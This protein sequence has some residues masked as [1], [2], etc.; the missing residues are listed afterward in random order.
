MDKSGRRQKRKERDRERERRWVAVHRPFDNSK[1]AFR[2]ALLRLYRRAPEEYSTLLKVVEIDSDLRLSEQDA[3]FREARL[4]I[5]RA[6]S[7]SSRLVCSRIPRDV[8]L[9]LVVFA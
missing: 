2:D 1:G 5:L 6:T 3:K 7:R 8:L 9:C 4:I